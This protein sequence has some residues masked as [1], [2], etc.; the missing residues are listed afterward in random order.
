MLVKGP[1]GALVPAAVLLV[2]FWFDPRKGALR[3][4]FAPVNFGIVLGLFLPWFAALVYAHPEFAHYG[5]I[6]ET[7][8]R[9]FTPAFNRGQ[10]FWYFGPVFLASLLPWTLLFVPMAVAAWSARDRL[11]RADRLFVV[12]TIVVILFFSMSR[13]KQPGYI[14][15]ATLAGAALVGRGLGYAWRNRGGRGARLVARGSLALAVFAVG[16]AAML[17]WAVARGAASAGQLAAEAAHRRSIWQMWPTLLVVLLVVAALAA[18]G[19][20]RKSAGLSVAAF[21]CFPLALVTAALPGVT[22]Y[23]RARSAEPLALSLAALPE[24]TEIACFEAYPAGLSFYLG[25]TIT[26]ISENAEPLRSNFILYWLRRV[27]ARPPSL[28]ARSAR[29]RW[30]AS[31]TRATY[32]LASGGASSDLASWLGGSI[33]VG[34]VA[35]GWSG[36]SVPLPGGR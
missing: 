35:P 14:L 12:W 27:P 31:R 8:N 29:D 6:E 25:R 18:A 33:P 2:F 9:F 15:T 30:M 7:F 4:V 10:P 21:A 11:T 28:V 20:A 24:D 26:I 36:A 19:Y 1:V 17:G 5:L 3:R 23:A 22:A 16:L 34:A 32:I 13:T